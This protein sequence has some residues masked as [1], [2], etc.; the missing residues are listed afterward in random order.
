MSDHVHRSDARLEDAL[1]PNDRNLVTRI[2]SRVGFMPT[3]D[4]DGLQIVGYATLTGIPCANGELLAAHPMEQRI[5]LR[6]PA[7]DELIAALTDLR[8]AVKEYL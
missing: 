5:A 4:G 2:T 3:M 8:D 6:P 1:D 7:I